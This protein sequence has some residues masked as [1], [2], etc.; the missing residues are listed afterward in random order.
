M[1]SLGS[2]S[3]PFQKQTLV[4]FFS[5]RIL[6]QASLLS[7]CRAPGAGGFALP[8]V[9]PGGDAAGPVKEQLCS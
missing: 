8:S 3:W 2:K 4:G 9:G 5:S 7:R 1:S 6:D